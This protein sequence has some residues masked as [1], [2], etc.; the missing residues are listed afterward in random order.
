MRRNSGV[1]NWISL[2]HSFDFSSQRGNGQC[3]FI[4]NAELSF[5]NIQD[6]HH[7]PTLF[8]VTLQNIRCQNNHKPLWAPLVNISAEYPAG[9]CYMIM[10]HTVVGKPDKA[11]S[12]FQVTASSDH[13]ETPETPNSTSI[14]SILYNWILYLKLSTPQR[15]LHLTKSNPFSPWRNTPWPKCP[16]NQ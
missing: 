12:F 3:I 15:L 5:I 1:K 11:I 6:I 2:S 16:G 4:T 13:S 10:T 7:S 9:Q 8:S 14:S